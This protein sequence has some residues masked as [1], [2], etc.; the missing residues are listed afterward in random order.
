M[1]RNKICKFC[2]K[3]IYKLLFSHG[4]NHDVYI[5]NMLYCPNCN[6]IMLGIKTVEDLLNSTVFMVSLI[7]EIDNFENKKK[8]SNCKRILKV[9]F[10][11]KIDEISRKRMKRYIMQ[12]R[13]CKRC[14]I[15]EIL[16]END[17]IENFSFEVEV[18]V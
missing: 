2:S 10:Y 13:V 7:P 14:L 1:G 15:L 11:R 16:P 9:P 18:K 4:H 17:L 12:L 5:E 6:I 8:C 3:D